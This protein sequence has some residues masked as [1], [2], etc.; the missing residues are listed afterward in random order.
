VRFQILTAASMKFKV[1]WNVASCSRFEVDRRFRDA[2]CLNYQGD[3]R[4]SQILFPLYVQELKKILKN[5]SVTII[6][7]IFTLF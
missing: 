7:S 6:T 4:Q 1:F 3:H 2:Y 5:V